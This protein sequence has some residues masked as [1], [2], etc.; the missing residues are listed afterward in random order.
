[1]SVTQFISLN[2]RL[3]CHRHACLLQ[4][5]LAEQVAGLPDDSYDM[6]PA[7]AAALQAIRSKE[8]K[9]CIK[10]TKVKKARLSEAD[11]KVSAAIP[12]RLDQPTQCQQTTE[13]AGNLPQHSQQACRC[14]GRQPAH[15]L[16]Q[17]GEHSSRNSDEHR[18]ALAHSEVPRKDNGGDDSSDDPEFPDVKLRFKL[19]R[20]RL[21]FGIPDATGLLQYGQAFFQPEMD[22][23]ATMIKGCAV[24]VSRF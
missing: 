8:V 1:M 17:Q 18:S 15:G 9:G 24:V 6:P 2:R 7:V 5:A 22:G 12:T 20:S 13:T 19:T 3:Q 23:E 4:F 14:G 11:A 21:A 16:P 10:E